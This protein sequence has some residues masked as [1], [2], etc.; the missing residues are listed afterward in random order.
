MRELRSS[1]SNRDEIQG[2]PRIRKVESPPLTRFSVWDLPSGKVAEMT[3][4]VAVAGYVV[5]HHVAD[6]LVKHVSGGEE[7][8]ARLIW[9]GP[10]RVI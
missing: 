8:S 6:L 10:M 1:I 3:V 9:T 2:A 5:E 4:L 7:N